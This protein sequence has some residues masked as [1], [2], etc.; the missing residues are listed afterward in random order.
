MT[1]TASRSVSG[2]T[3][4]SSI[5][6]APPSTPAPQSQQAEVPRQV[7]DLKSLPDLDPAAVE[8]MMSM[9]RKQESAEKNEDNSLD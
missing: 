3:V 1:Q 6:R 2:T 7:F 5:V 4:S 9:L 8:A